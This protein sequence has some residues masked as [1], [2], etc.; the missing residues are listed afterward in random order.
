MVS[1]DELAF[2]CLCQTFLY[3]F[4]CLPTFVTSVSNLVVPKKNFIEN[5]ILYLG[6][7]NTWTCH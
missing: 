1:M 6:P 7:N 4:F 5:N 2:I 3:K